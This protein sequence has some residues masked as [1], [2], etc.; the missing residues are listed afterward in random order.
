MK[1]EG[2]IFCLLFFSILFLGSFIPTSSVSALH[3]NSDKKES[4][5]NASNL[6][7]DNIYA[8]PSVSKKTEINVELD[9]SPTEKL[10][11]FGEIV[12]RFSLP[13]SYQDATVKVVDDVYV[14]Y[15]IKT[16]NSEITD[17]LQ[18]FLDK[19]DVHVV[20]KGN[21]VATSIIHVPIEHIQSLTNNFP[22]RALQHS[23]I[24]F[25]QPNFYYEAAYIPDDTYWADQ[26]GPQI[27]GM[28][29]AWDVQLGSSSIRVAVVDTGIDYAHPDLSN[30]YLAIGYDFVNSD[31]NPM[32]DNG[33][34]THCAGTIAAS[35]NNALGIAGIADVSVFAEK[36]LDEWGYGDSDSLAACIDH[37]VSQGADVISNSWGGYG[38]D[39]L[40]ST[41]VANAVLAGVV[42][43]AA[44]GNDN[45]DM[46]FYP[47]AYPDVISVS[48]T[49]SGDNKA[50]FSN[51]GDWIDVAAPGVSIYSTLPDNS[52]GY[53]QGTSMACPHVAGLIALILSEFPA[54]TM[55]QIYNLITTTAVDLGDPG[56]DYLF[57]WGRIDGISSIYGLQDHNVRTTIISPSKIP[58]IISTD[59]MVRVSN[60]GLY[61]ETNLNVTLYLDDISVDNRILDS[62]TNGNSISYYYEFTPPAEGTYN[63]TA[64]VDPVAGEIVLADNVCQRFV[65]AVPKQI[66]AKLGDILAYSE[67]EGLY[68]YDFYKW[69]IVEIISPTEYNISMNYFDPYSGIEFVGGYFIL[70]PYTRQM[71][72]LFDLF[73][74]WINTTG[75]SIGTTFDFFTLGSNDAEVINE[76]TV[77]YY[78]Q[79]IPVW[80]VDDGMEWVYLDK[81]NGVLFAV[82]YTNS[83]SY[84]F[85]MAFTNV[86]PTGYE[87]HNLKVITGT[88]FLNGSEYT[89]P[90][91]IQNTGLYTESSTLIFEIN[92]SVIESVP[93]NLDSEE[94]LFYDLYWTPAEEAVYNLSISLIPAMGETYLVDNYDI[95]LFSTFVPRNYYMYPYAYNWFDAR[96]NGYNLGV[97][98]DDTYGSVD[99]PFTFE[100]Y[101]QNFDTV[102]ISSNGW[103]SFTETTP[104][105]YWN[106]EFPSDSFGYVIAPFWDDLQA[107]D[108]IYV[109]ETADFVV[110]EFY[111][112]SY[113][114]SELIGNFEVIL[115][116]TGEIIFQYDYVI[117][118]SGATIGLNYGLDMYYYTAYTNGLTAVDDFALL[119]TTE[120]P[121]HELIV[122]L[123][124]PAFGPKDVEYIINATVENGGKNNETDVEFELYLNDILVDSV[125]I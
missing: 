104:Y 71:N 115:N 12:S 85:D 108:N 111:N 27:M 124:A 40:I 97:Y 112:Y 5:L 119:F 63:F 58:D 98:G 62:L 82:G 51:Y 77:F 81:E 106:P 30:Q 120:R 57:G 29:D 52:Y 70:N 107:T 123:E 80:V 68:P 31:S 103:M 42:V 72:D 8:N 4:F 121:D 49:D 90:L 102:Y 84:Y 67:N 6:K 110:I 125:T 113:L 14:E 38:E 105:E 89:T 74:F 93:I 50:S 43:V 61:D 17:V 21:N 100:F 9:I 11:T 78:G 32:D 64:V 94:Y 41:A 2:K 95:I 7:A 25:I 75:F 18:N 66:D 118:D 65:D 10:R 16:T 1:K 86:I 48:A 36:G 73:P 28:T 46:L 91:F 45:T 15:L 23:E 35:I 96:T 19:Y 60:I 53:A 114:G 47:A 92:S 117:Y 20:E 3:E 69:E 37:A 44:A 24:K 79:E 56:F 76:T 13:S 109:W 99:L 33:H 88:S 26:W 116:R 87:S 122:Y 83:S 39:T 34:G 59:I 55:T 54:Y 101:E 22:D